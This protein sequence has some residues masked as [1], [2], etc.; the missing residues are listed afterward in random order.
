MGPKAAIRKL[1]SLPLMGI[2]NR[3]HARAGVGMMGYISLP[4]MG[5]GNTNAGGLERWGID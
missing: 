1:T 3:V 4:L 2:G 5:I